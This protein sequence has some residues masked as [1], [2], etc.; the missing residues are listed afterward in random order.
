MIKKI[1]IVALAMYLASCNVKQPIPE[2]IEKSYYDSVVKG[3]EYDDSL[4]LLVRSQ[5]DSLKYENHWLMD[6][7]IYR[8]CL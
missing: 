2:M 4:F 6:S 3:K 1:V 5:C 8:Q 7:L